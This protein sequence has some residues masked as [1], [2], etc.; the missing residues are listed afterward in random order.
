M[1]RK[2]ISLIIITVAL[3]TVMGSCNL[4]K[5]FETPKEGLVGEYATAVAE[6]IDSTALGNLS[7][8]EMFTDPVLQSF[9]RTALDNNIDLKNAKL[10][11][12]IAQ[13]QLLGAKLSYLPSLT[14]GPNG[15]GSSMAGSSMG[16]S[17]QLPLAASWEIDIFG[18][19]TNSKR[20][21][22]AA[23]LQS[24][25]YHQAVRSQIIG[26]VANVYYAI[27]SLEKQLALSRETADKWKESVQVMKDMKE[28]GRFTEVAVVQS[29]ANY[30]SVL[31]SIPDI[32]MS[33]HELNNTMSLLLKEQPKMWQVNVHSTLIV[34]A[35]LEAG[36]PMSYLAV[37]PDVKASEQAL[38]QAYYATNKARA[39]FYPSLVISANGGFTNLIGGII[40]NPGAWFVQL[41]G[42]LTAPLFARGQNIANLKA[43]K[44]QQAQSLNSFEYTIL[45]ASAEVSDAFVQLTKNSQKKDFLKIQVNNLDKAVAF[46]EDLLTL[47]TTTYLEVLTAQQSLLNAQMQELSCELS[48]AKAGISLYQS[49]GGGR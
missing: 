23:L 29:T 49:L 28:A 24:E 47:G 41:A 5:S 13:A 40:T 34:P 20:Q 19:I 2:N 43:T 38:A 9:I 22:K 45:N 8:E 25:A 17:Y 3:A 36:V 39:S 37:R 18:K 21:A 33:L 14:L 11:I 12:D 1:L 35:K 26:S 30:Y 27:V 42:Q 4:Y 44:A 16:W 48:I 31:A 6:P 7:W 15:S 10:N 32:E 46:N